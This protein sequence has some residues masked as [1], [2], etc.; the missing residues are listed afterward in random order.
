LQTKETSDKKDDLEEQIDLLTAK[1]DS[2]HSSMQKLKDET[3]AANDMLVKIA[4]QQKEM[5][6]L[7][8]EEHMD[9]VKAKADLDTGLQSVRYAMKT[10]NAY[11]NKEEDA[12]SFAQQNADSVDF[13]SPSFAQQMVPELGGLHVK[14]TADS[15]AGNSII[16]ILQLIEA[17]FGKNL[18]TVETDEANAAATYEKT[19]QNN[20]LETMALQEDVKY[21]VRTTR[22]FEKHV[23]DKQTDR[24]NA[25]TELDSETEYAKVVHDKCTVKPE[26][27]EERVA[28]RQEE[29]EGLNSAL[30]SLGG[31]FEE[32]MFMQTRK[33]G[34]LQRH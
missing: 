7:R 11:Y 12:A 23:S 1:I 19:T 10:L 5:D 34:F 17:D 9:F 16:G 4:T 18:A 30:E 32:G 2:A 27:Y 28:R 24:E 29:I 31:E 20:E 14:H 22:A 6:K 25:A 33:V 8:K 26:T 13:S 21:K 3:A 15:G